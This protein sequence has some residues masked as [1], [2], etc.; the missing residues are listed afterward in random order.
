MPIDELIV[1]GGPDCDGV[2]DEVG[3]ADAAAFVFDDE[4][5][6]PTDGTV[7]IDEVGCPVTGIP[8]FDDKVGCPD[9]GPAELE[10]DGGCAG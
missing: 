10:D 2:V 1:L 7:L 5:G 8:P 6:C 9:G 3:T 4:D